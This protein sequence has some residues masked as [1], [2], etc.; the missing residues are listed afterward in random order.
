VWT[1]CWHYGTNDGSGNAFSQILAALP[2][3]LFQQVNIL[4]LNRLIERLGH[5]VDR[6]RGYGGRRERFHFHT[7][8]RGRRGAGNDA[9]TFR[10]HLNLHVRVRKHERMAERNQIGSLLGGAN[11]GYAR[12]F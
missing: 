6:Q 2:T 3:A 8:L 12:D 1:R 9:H 11:P 4:N 7:S 5:V 10:L